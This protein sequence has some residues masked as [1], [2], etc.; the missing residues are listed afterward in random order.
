MAMCNTQIPPTGLRHSFPQMLGKVVLSPKALSENWSQ[1]ELAHQI[2]PLPLLSQP[3]TDDCSRQRCKGPVSL[4]QFK[5]ILKD[6]SSPR[7]P[8]RVCWDFLCNHI[9]SSAH[10]LLSSQP[11]FLCF[12]SRVDLHSHPSS[13]TS[14]KSLSWGAWT[15][16]K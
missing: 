4:L 3:F 1:R 15:K 12:A 11:Y 10:R 9:T 7:A 8:C 6:Q 5:T 16:T 2:T 13:C 14:S